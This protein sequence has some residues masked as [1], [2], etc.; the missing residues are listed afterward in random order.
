MIKMAVPCSSLVVDRFEMG[1]QP[2]KWSISKNLGIHTTND[3]VD[4]CDK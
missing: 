2:Q 1:H 4:I 3:G